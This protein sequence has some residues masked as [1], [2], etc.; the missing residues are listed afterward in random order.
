MIL[1]CL[2]KAIF[3]FLIYNIVTL[4]IFGVPKSLSMTFYLFKERLDILK[5]LFPSMITMLV[6][7]LMPCWIQISEGSPFQ[8]LSFLSAASLLFVGFAPSFKSSSL[9]NNVHQISAYLCAL[10]SILWIVLVTPYWYV[11]LIVLGIVTALAIVTK[12]WKTC[13]IYWLEMV[14][15]VS[16]FISILCYWEVYIK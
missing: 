7:C 13:Y 10:C 6:I 9:E 1:D 15:F 2:V 5:V 8:F 3:L 16:T 4:L 14:A 12:T 11:I